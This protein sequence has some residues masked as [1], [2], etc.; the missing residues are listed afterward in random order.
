MGAVFGARL[1]GFRC[2]LVLLTLAAIGLNGCVIES[3][4]DGDSGGGGGSGG[5]ST[6][7]PE[8][9]A[10]FLD[11][12]TFGATPSGVERVRELGMEQWIEEQFDAPMSNWDDT[13][14]YGYGDSHERREPGCART[15]RFRNHRWFDNALTG[16]DQLR[17]RVA[18]ALS[19]IWVVSAKNTGEDFNSHGPH[20]QWHGLLNEH[21]LGN[22]R[23]LM[24]AATKSPMMGDF[25]DMACSRDPRSDGVAN[26][27]YARELLQL[28]TLGIHERNMDATFKRDANGERIPIYDGQQVQAFARAFTGWGYSATEEGR[29]QGKQDQFCI[30]NNDY[31]SYKEPMRA[32]FPNQHASGTKELLN[33]ER[34]PAGQSAE[35]DLNGALDNI[36]NHPNIA[37]FV[38]EQ[39]IQHLV[40]SNPSP[41]YVRD[42]ARTFAGRGNHERGDM[43]AVVKAILLHPEARR[44]DDPDERRQ[45]G[46]HLREPILLMTDVIRSLGADVNPA[47]TASNHYGDGNTGL[48]W[49][50]HFFRSAKRMGQPLHEALS[51]FSFYPPDHVSRHAQGLVAPEF[52]IMD[53]S[54]ALDRTNFV[55]LV[56]TGEHPYVRFNQS[57]D[58]QYRRWAEEDPEALLDELDSM[59]LHG[60]MSEAMRSEIRRAMDDVRTPHD[61]VAIAVYLVGTSP[62]YQVLH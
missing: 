28:F 43:Q 40:M 45:D 14:C 31:A 38:S 22:Y 33:G 3:E 32:G 60:A 29:D 19:Q 12:A 23:E 57:E 11:Q 53:T 10:R 24:E 47:Q 25:L 46:G 58:T 39:L 62:Q 41:E 30:Y 8:A 27:N 49:G 56:S 51:V 34:L 36:F 26:E 16:Q 35:Q 5:G 20:V 59:M 61:K 55:D 18:F 4:D 1:P 15:D 44:G 7:S 48:Q 37:P 54:T 21:A 52:A 50:E 17:Q 9:A 42:V 6:P 13:P 2:V